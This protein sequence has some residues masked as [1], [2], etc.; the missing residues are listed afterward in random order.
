MKKS[1][2]IKLASAAPATD[3]VSPKKMAAKINRAITEVF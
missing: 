3:T 1:T 2:I